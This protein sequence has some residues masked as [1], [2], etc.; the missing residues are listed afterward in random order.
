MRAGLVLLLGLGCGAQTVPEG[1][2]ATFGT[3]VVASSGLRGEIYAIPRGEDVLFSFRGLKKLGE[4]YT[5]SLR[6]APRRFQDGFPGVTARTEWFGI[7]YTGQFWVEKSAVYRFR[8]LAD[9]GA[10][11]MI[12]GKLLIDNDGLHAPLAVE[13][14]AHLTRGIHRIRVPYFQGPRFEVALVLSVAGPDGGEWRIFDTE[15]FRPPPDPGEW[16]KGKI[17]KVKRGSNW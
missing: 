7:D 13:G 5:T 4:I 2:V 9:D 14:S 10:K 16:I 6:V 8:L 3:T 12:D 1:P 15:E 17:S 11:L